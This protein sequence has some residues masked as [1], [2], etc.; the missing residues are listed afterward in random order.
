MDDEIRRAIALI[1]R[2]R[3]LDCSDDLTAEQGAEAMKQIILGVLHG[4]EELIE[5]LSSHKPSVH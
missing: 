5:C 4:N 2:C 1:E 3:L